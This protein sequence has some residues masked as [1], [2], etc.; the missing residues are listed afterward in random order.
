MTKKGDTLGTYWDD[1]R[2]PSHTLFIHY[3]PFHPYSQAF[4]TSTREDK[5]WLA[6]VKKAREYGAL[7][8][9]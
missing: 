8:G 4:K 9:S 1:L 6:E 5:C 3:T 2:A 7:E